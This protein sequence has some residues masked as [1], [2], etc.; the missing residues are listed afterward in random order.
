MARVLKR[1]LGLVSLGLWAIEVLG[2]GQVFLGFDV[3]VFLKV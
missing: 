2:L 3:R 1:H